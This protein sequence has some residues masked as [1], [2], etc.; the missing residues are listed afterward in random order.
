MR[1]NLA[2]KILGHHNQVIGAQ[3]RDLAFEEPAIGRMN[4]RN[5][6]SIHDKHAFPAVL[7]FFLA[8]DLFFTGEQG[9]AGPGCAAEQPGGVVG[10]CHGREAFVIGGRGDVLRLVDDEKRP[11]GRTDHIG[12]RLS[13][14]E[15]GARPLNLKDVA[16]LALPG[17]TQSQIVTKAIRKPV[18]R[19][20]C[21][22]CERG[23]G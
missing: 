9:I 20:P 13:G 18:N 7:L 3:A 6:G 23:A 12:V 1:I 5:L 14:K 17:A 11:S 8:T 19:E 15:M 21:L 16:C 4:F 2:A 22:G 10:G